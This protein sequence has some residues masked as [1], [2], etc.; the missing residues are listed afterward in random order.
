MAGILTAGS[1]LSTDSEL[2]LNGVKGQALFCGDLLENSKRLAVNSIM[3]DRV[4]CEASLE[5]LRGLEID[6]V[7][8]GHGRPF[9]WD[10]FL[11]NRRGN[12]EEE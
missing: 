10:S 9:L 4:A 12:N 1:T 5:K 3:D 8:P 6:T 7:Y 2:A 11:A